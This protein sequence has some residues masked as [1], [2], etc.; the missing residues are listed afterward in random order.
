MS[1]SGGTDGA[2]GGRRGRTGGVSGPL[3]RT[4]VQE[5]GRQQVERI[6]DAAAE[7]IAELGVDAATTNAM[8]ARAQVSVGSLYQYFPD[9]AALVRALAVRYIAALEE[10]LPVPAGDDPAG[11][12]LPEEVTRAVGVLADFIVR[13]PAYTHVYR[14]ARAS[15]DEDSVRLL[16]RSKAHFEAVFKRRAPGVRADARRA[17]ATVVVEAA[18]ALLVVAAGEP[19]R[20][21][22]RLIRELTDMLIRYLEPVYG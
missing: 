2:G 19:T 7:V 11:W 10:T 20:Q 4:P 5:R 14:A 21:Q 1:G 8:A 6:L 13:H 16:D 12:S 3:R 15:S 18:Q 9:K 17:H 22:R